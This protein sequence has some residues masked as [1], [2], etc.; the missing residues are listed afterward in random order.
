MGSMCIVE[1][2]TTLT[3]FTLVALMAV[4]DKAFA[5]DRILIATIVA[6]NNDGYHIDMNRSPHLNHDQIFNEGFHYHA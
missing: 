2:K 1:L 6:R 4:S 5:P 3:G